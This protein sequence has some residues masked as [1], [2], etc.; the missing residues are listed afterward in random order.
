MNRKVLV[1]M[2]GGVPTLYAEQGIDVAS[3]DL[4]DVELVDA[5]DILSLHP[6]FSPLLELAGISDI[7]PVSMD[8]ISND[9][10][11]LE[12]KDCQQENYVASKG[13]R[14]PFC[15]SNLINHQG[16]PLQADGGEVWADIFC[17]GCS[18][19]WQDHYQLVGFTD[20]N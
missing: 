15:G 4:D 16:K 18:A 14:C 17:F 7:W 12:G 8:G 20:L 5:E 10:D 2:K 13:Q 9:A 3:V 11:Y 6:S 1:V 19:S